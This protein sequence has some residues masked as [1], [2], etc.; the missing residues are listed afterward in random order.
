MYEADEN[1][2]GAI[3]GTGVSY[4]R[5]GHIGEAM[6]PPQPFNLETYDTLKDLYWWYCKQDAY[7]SLISTDPLMYVHQLNLFASSH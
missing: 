3:C 1:I 2:V 6:P 7:H 4:D 5:Y